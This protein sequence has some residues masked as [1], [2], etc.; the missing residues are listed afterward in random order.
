M[1]STT[2]RAVELK[3]TR[4]AK[5]RELLQTHPPLEACAILAVEEGVNLSTAKRYLQELRL[6][7]MVPESAAIEAILRERKAPKEAKTA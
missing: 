7:G 5:L 6:A 3:R 1:V 2:E 4:V